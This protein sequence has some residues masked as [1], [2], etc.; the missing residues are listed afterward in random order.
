MAAT[1][2][3]VEKTARGGR[4]GAAVVRLGAEQ[5]VEELARMASGAAVTEATRHHARELLR[6]GRRRRTVAPTPRSGP[7]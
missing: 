2:L 5:R 3:R 7:E 4:A 1:H 6:G